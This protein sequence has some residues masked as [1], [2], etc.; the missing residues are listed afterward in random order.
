MTPGVS[1]HTSP[2]AGNLD[3]MFLP[4]VSPHDGD[5]RVVMISFR[6]MFNLF[7][8]RYNF[9]EIRGN[10]GLVGGSFPETP[11]GRVR[12]LRHGTLEDVMFEETYA[13][14]QPHTGFR[15]AAPS[16]PHAV[17]ITV[18][19]CSG[20][21]KDIVRQKKRVVQDEED[22]ASAFRKS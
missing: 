1:Y 3:H 12:P 19:E 9:Y 15:A 6:L 10:R 5:N 18:K 2:P 16:M 14:Q 8:I 22:I 17:F 13:W 21:A 11:G 4:V 7:V 20:S